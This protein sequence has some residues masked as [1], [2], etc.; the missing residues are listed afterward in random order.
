MRFKTSCLQLEF[1]N[2]HKDQLLIFYILHKCRPITED[3]ADLCLQSF[4][5]VLSV[6][7]KMMV[8][9]DLQLNVLIREIDKAV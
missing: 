4:L 2:P 6:K 9:Q 8:R 7:V 1:L 5:Y 3:G